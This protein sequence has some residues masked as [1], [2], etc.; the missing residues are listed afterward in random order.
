LRGGLLVT[1][2]L[3]T[4]AVVYGAVTGHEKFYRSVLMPAVRLIDP[5]QA[6]VLAVKLAAWGMLP[7]DRSF[8]DKILVSENFRLVDLF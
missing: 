7:K 3:G 8:P 2:S 5:E 1:G 6:H 4:G